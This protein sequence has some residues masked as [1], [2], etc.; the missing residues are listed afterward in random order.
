M[1]LESDKQVLSVLKRQVSSFIGVTLGVQPFLEQ[2][3]T[4]KEEEEEE[5]ERLSLATAEVKEEEHKKTSRYLW[6]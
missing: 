2:R 5:V 1:S 4:V 6:S 3:E